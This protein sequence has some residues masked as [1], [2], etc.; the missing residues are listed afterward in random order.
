MAD[1]ND[2]NQH[3]IYY[4]VLSWN[5][6]RYVR[7]IFSYLELTVTQVCCMTKHITGKMLKV[8]N[9]SA[10][11]SDFTAFTAQANSL[12]CFL[13]DASVTNLGRKISVQ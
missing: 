3:V 4:L 13:G 10:W 12:H 2:I 1:Y 7:A 11:K 5:P 9:V 6:Y 8:G